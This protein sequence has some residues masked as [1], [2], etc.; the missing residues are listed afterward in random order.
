MDEIKLIHATKSKETSQ[1][2]SACWLLATIS[3][4]IYVR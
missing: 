2:T 4:N 3:L 1:T